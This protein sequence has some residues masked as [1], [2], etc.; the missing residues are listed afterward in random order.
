MSVICFFYDLL[1]DRGYAGYI[2]HLG[3]EGRGH[4]SLGIGQGHPSV[5]RLEGPAVVGAISAHSHAVLQVLQMLDELGFLSRTHSGKDRAVHCK[6]PPRI[7]STTT[8]VG[9]I[10]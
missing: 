5:R 1:D 8:S 10:L 6:L 2:L 7:K 9:V 3:R 4:G